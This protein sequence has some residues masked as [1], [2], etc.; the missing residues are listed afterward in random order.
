MFTRIF[1]RSFLVITLIAAQS[2][3]AAIITGPDAYGF[4]ARTFD[5]NLRDIQHIGTKL[6]GDDDRTFRVPIGFAYAFNGMTTNDIDV[7]IN[8]FLKNRFGNTTLRIDGYSD[9]LQSYGPPLSGDIYY[10]TTGTAGSREF[11][12]GYYGVNQYPAGVLDMHM[13]FEIILHEG[14]NNIEYQFAELFD[15]NRVGNI[16]LT[17]FPFDPDNNLSISNAAGY[18]ENT[19]YLISQIP[20]PAAAWLF[21]SGLVVLIGVARRTGTRQS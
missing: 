9:D 18:H 11:I 6:P 1:P 20:I 3:F 21:G 8:G 17:Y 10:H 14:S 16:G 7:S 4:A 12:V 19:G 5:F 2:S 13:T 15:R